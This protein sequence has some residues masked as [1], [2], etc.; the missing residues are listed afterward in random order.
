MRILRSWDRHVDIHVIKQEK[1]LDIL[2]NTKVD[3]TPWPERI[4]LRFLRET[5]EEIAGGLTDI[6]VF[7]LITGK[8][9]EDWRIVNCVP[10]FKGGNR[11]NP[12]HYGEPGE[13]YISAPR[14]LL[15]IL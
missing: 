3:E 2:K 12:T 14:K 15:K 7:S 6:F 9:P 5:T 4:Y 13:P 1:V 11:D 10:L 8:V